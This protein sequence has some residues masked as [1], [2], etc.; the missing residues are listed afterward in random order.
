MKKF[1]FLLAALTAACLA[2]AYSEQS[3]AIDNPDYFVSEKE[4]TWYAA[5]YYCYSQGWNLVSIAN[6]E[7]TTLLKG[8]REFYAFTG[9][10]Y[11]SAG[12]RL[13]SKKWLW[14]LGGHKFSYLNWASGQGNNST[15]KK[16]LLL[17]E[18]ADSL[19]SQEDC[20]KMQKFICQKHD[21]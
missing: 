18:T 2:T 6:F 21:F 16:C 9:T 10:S 3:K 7:A 11:W 4:H 1:A 20:T 8:F 5:N 15:E 17:G 19:W 13:E 14:G 12:N